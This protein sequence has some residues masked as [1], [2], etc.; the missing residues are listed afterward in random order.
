MIKNILITSITYL[1]LMVNL[2]AAGSDGGVLWNSTAPTSTLFSVG[3]NDGANGDGKN[4][5]AKRVLEI[6]RQYEQ[7]AKKW[8]Q[9]YAYNG[10]EKGDKPY[11]YEKELELAE[12]LLFKANEYKGVSEQR[13]KEI[14]RLTNGN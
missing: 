11:F 9:Y 12:R 2:N 1:L 10:D 7:A 3:D 5:D 8:V 13:I 14:N 6:I 4:P